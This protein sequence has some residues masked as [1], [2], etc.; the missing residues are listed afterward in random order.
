MKLLV[1]GASGV[2][3]NRLYN[4]AIKK[5]WDILGT[6]YAHAYEGMVYLDLRDKSGIEKTFHSFKPD[7][8]ILAGGITNVDLSELNPK[9]SEDINIKGASNLVKK[10]KEYGAR[11]VYISTDYVFDGENGPYEENDK[12]NPIN[13]YGCTKLEAEN[14]VSYSLK[15][16]LIVRTSQIYGV[17]PLNNNFAAKIIYNMKNHKKVYAADDFY[18]TPTYTGLLSNMCLKLIE[19]RLKGI[20]NAAGSDFINRYDYVHKIADIFKLDKTLIEKVKLK[21]LK[22]KAK[23][24]KMGGL[25]VDKIKK[26]IGIELLSCTKGLKLL[27]KEF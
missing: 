9:L 25:K 23:R 2:F 26:E 21:D 14:I 4:E 18:S 13:V 16:Y 15:D 22:L 12:P 19:K 5:K 27:K 10:I 1:I 7:V 8:V 20:Y 3:G 17:D 24:P 11:L 6:Y